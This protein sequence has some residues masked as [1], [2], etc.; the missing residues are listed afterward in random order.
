[1][2]KSLKNF[3]TIKAL[4]K[5]VPPRV[6]KLFFAMHKYDVVL[7]YDPET[8]LTEAWAKDKRYKNF[9]GSLKTT[10]RDSS[11]SKPQKLDNVDF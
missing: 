8:S 3:I 6:L 4:I 11:I 7:D 1:M 5:Q 2:S 9:L 10:I